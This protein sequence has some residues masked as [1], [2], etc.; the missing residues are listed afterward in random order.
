MQT[1]PPIICIFTEGEGDGI[2]SRLSF[3]NL[4]TLDKIEEKEIPVYFI[5]PFS[6]EARNKT[7]STSFYVLLERVSNLVNRP[8]RALAFF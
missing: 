3:K 8:L 1:F 2:K 7:K 4:S 5:F 6:Y